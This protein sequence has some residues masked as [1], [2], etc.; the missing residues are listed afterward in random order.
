MLFTIIPDITR[1]P[2]PSLAGAYGLGRGC[3]TDAVCFSPVSD[4]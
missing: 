1:S 4:G 3:V 2:E